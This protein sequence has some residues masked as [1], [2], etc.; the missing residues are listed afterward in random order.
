MDCKH[1]GILSKC[2][3]LIVIDEVDSA[4]GSDFTKVCTV[5]ILDGT[6][7][8]TGH[9]KPFQIWVNLVP[10]IQS[11]DL[12]SGKQGEHAKTH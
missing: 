5:Y 3:F 1:E 2:F 11:H 12:G 8:R 10:L 9:E 6:P 4:L 7:R